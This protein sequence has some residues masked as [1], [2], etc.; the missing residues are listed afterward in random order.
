MAL[1]ANDAYYHIFSAVQGDG[2]P[3]SMF[4][5]DVV[6][7]GTADYTKIQVYPP[8]Y[9]QNQ[10]VWVG[11]KS[12]N[13]YYM[14]DD[15]SSKWFS[16]WSSKAKDG[17][18]V[19]I[20][21]DRNGNYA[22]WYFQE[23]G[24]ATI[25]GSTYPTYYI[26][27][28]GSSSGRVLTA[29]AGSSGPITIRPVGY[30]DGANGTRA[31]T[32]SPRQ[33]WMLIPTTEGANSYTV[34]SSGGAATSKVSSTS[35]VVVAESGN[36]YP[37]WAGSRTVN[38]IRYKTR[39]RAIGGSLGAWS[40][41]KCINN[42][43]TYNIGWGSPPKT[44]YVTSTKNGN[45]RISN[46]ALAMTTLGSTYDRVDYCFQ[47]REY[48]TGTYWHGRRYGFTVSQVKQP[49]VDTASVVWAPDGLYVNWTTSNVRGG[50]TMTVE[51]TNGLFSKRTESN[52]DGSDGLFIPSSA[53]KRQVM[54]GDT[55]GIKVTVK[56][57]EGATGSRTANTTVTSESSVGTAVTI[58]STVTN[59]LATVSA[60]G[61][62]QKAWLVIPTG[63]GN[64]YVRLSGSSPWKFPPPLG[65]P[66]SV[67]VTSSS[68]G[69][70]NAKTQEFPAVIEYPPTHHITSQDLEHD[71]P[72]R[73]RVGER[74]PEMQVTYTRSRAEVE[75]F[76]RARPASSYGSTTTEEWTVT[77]DLIGD[78]YLD[79]V[80]HFAED[81]HVFY[82]GPFGYWAQ[83][84]I[85]SVSVDLTTSDQHEVSVSLRGE[86]W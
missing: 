41:W 10:V 7:S 22:K 29:P 23:V 62:E 18:N 21:H 20:W 34:P 9:G 11:Y 63:N 56:T 72:I 25:N 76:G 79:E 1:P 2:T 52:T 24:T 43:S 51:S 32:P 4:C 39:T 12:G 67:Y 60:S 75:T 50:S 5:T 54:P 13:V 8:H 30:P 74:G 28:L 53:L 35:T 65:V 80:Y 6:G 86:V 14:W 58:N 33:L 31:S 57:A 70:Y 59:G 44:T 27:A 37:S 82:R 45:R 16:T 26:R 84:G 19:C 17:E 55:V 61:S 3:E 68:G 69:T 15:N 71:L 81:S 66:Y 78:E 46:T 47:V 38:Q 73:F 85:E 40:H 36:L 42:G 64:R 49:T 83:A 77:G 48:D